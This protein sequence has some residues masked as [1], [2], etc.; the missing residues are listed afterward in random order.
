MVYVFDSVI[1]EIIVWKGFD[2][3]GK[4]R[5]FKK[6]GGLLGFLRVGVLL[7]VWLRGH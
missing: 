7:R 3:F 6:I 5:V 4:P 2:S 1:V